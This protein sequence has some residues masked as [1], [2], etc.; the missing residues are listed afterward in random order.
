MCICFWVIFQQ[1]KR[2]EKKNSAQKEE[3]KRLGYCQIVSQYNG[4]LYCDTVGFG[5]LVGYEIILQ[6]NEFVL[7]LRAVGCWK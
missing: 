3:Q 4:T 1:L 6:D 7:Q 5:R 2:K